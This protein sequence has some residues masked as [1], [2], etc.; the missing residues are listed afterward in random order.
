[1][2]LSSEKNRSAASTSGGSSSNAGNVASEDSA[3]KK[4]AIAGSGGS[5]DDPS[6]KLE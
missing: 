4:F 2:G 1:M 6:G 5:F 3:G